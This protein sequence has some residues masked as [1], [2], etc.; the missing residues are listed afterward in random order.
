[1]ARARRYERA[2]RQIESERRNLDDR[3]ADAYHRGHV[4][5]RAAALA[6]PATPAVE[7]AASWLRTSLADGALP[8]RELR[9]DAE[10]AGIAFRTLKRAKR[11][12]GVESV[13]TADGWLWR[14]VPSGPS[15]S[16]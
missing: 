1:M 16:G 6:Q 15:A 3:I 2:V 7:V 9:A 12:L 11:V 14:S 10:A 4:D 13:R 5:G 8:A